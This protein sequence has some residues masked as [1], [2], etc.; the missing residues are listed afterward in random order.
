FNPCPGNSCCPPF[1]FIYRGVCSS[2]HPPHGSY[3]SF[4]SA[5][6][7]ESSEC[8][9]P[10]PFAHTFHEDPNTTSAPSTPGVTHEEAIDA[11]RIAVRASRVAQK[12]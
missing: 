9:D 4:E 7:S 5:E 10:S 6:S 8:I 3:E 2:G 1:T 11:N 12:A